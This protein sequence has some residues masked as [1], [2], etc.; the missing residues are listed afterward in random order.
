MTLQKLGDGQNLLRLSHQFAVGEDS[1]YSV[2]TT[3][4][5]KQ[6]LVSPITNITEVSLTTNQRISEMNG[7][8]PDVIPFVGD[9]VTINPMDIRTFTFQNGS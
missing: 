8:F 6:I 4:N 9:L 2:P 1:K 3:I 5:L 7:K